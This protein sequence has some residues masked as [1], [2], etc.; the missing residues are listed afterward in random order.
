M[1]LIPPA[2]LGAP[3]TS[4]TWADWYEKVRREI[5]NA[6]SIDLSSAT[7][8][9]I[10]PVAKGGN[11]TATPNLVAGANTF[12]VDR[13]NYYAEVFG[14]LENIFKIFRVDLITAY[15]PGLGNTYGVRVGLGGLLGGKVRF[16]E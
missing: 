7:I 8:T 2:P 11:G 16:S 10:L 9:G 12:F 15:Q 13:N 3:F 1:A 5:N 14:G 4:Y 6:S